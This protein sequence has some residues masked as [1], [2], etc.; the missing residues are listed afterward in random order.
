MSH[1]D[2]DEMTNKSKPSC[3]PA[4]VKQ[5]LWSP[6]GQLAPRGGGGLPQG[7]DDDDEH[8]SRRVCKTVVY[9]KNERMKIR[10]IIKLTK[11]NKSRGCGGRECALGGTSAMP[12]LST[13][14][15]GSCA[16]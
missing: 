16:H 8:L 3:A 1:K 9:F 2:D 15:K 6:W 7:G 10:V 11:N 12:P 5:I 4:R 14:R 13:Y